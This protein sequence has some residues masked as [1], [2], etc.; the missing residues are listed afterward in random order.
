M[1]RFTASPAVTHQ[2]LAELLTAAGIRVE[3]PS[4]QDD[5]NAS[6]PRFVSADELAH[7]IMQLEDHSGSLGYI[8]FPGPR[9]AIRTLRDTNLYPPARRSAAAGMPLDGETALRLLRA[10][11][12][13]SRANEV[14]LQP[15]TIATH[16]SGPYLEWDIEQRAGL[17]YRDTPAHLTSLT[18]RSQLDL[19]LIFSR[20]ALLDSRLQVTQSSDSENNADFDIVIPAARFQYFQKSATDDWEGSISLGRLEGGAFTYDGLA[21]D[22]STGSVIAAASAGYTGFVPQQLAVLPTAPTEQLGDRLWGD[23]SFAPPRIVFTGSLLLPEI[24]GRH[25]PGVSTAVVVDHDGDQDLT[26]VR[27]SLSGPMGTAVFYALQGDI[28]VTGQLAWATLASLRWYPQLFRT[29]QMG[30]AAAAAGSADQNNSEYTPLDVDLPVAVYGGPFSNVAALSASF[31]SRIAEPL[32]LSASTAL[33]ARLDPVGVGD[34]AASHPNNLPLGAESQLQ[35]SLQ[36]VRDLFFDLKGNIFVPWNDSY[37]GAYPDES[38]L[39]WGVGIQAT[40]RL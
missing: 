30:L 32:R 37:G 14:T 11:L 35:L 4:L 22:I 28:Q 21:A 9:Y 15:R 39:Q 25:N 19:S 34:P 24:V 12:A 5:A 3:A 36:P 27:A 10:A 1:E 8:L 7:V 2:Q 13:E 6:D 20:T 18:S 40:V 31:R 26:Q 29:T 17:T 33:L 16:S 23:G 38:P